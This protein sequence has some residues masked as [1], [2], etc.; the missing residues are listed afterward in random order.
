MKK[1]QHNTKGAIP[2]QKSGAK[3]SSLIIF[4]FG[5]SKCNLKHPIVFTSK[6]KLPYFFITGEC[7]HRSVQVILMYMLSTRIR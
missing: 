2:F 4:F 6:C 1:F 7:A 5:K 3:I